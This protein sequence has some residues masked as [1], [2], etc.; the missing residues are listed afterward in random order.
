MKKWIAFFCALCLLLPGCGK[1]DT[2]AADGTTEPTEAEPA[3]V[4]FA[5]SEQDMFTDRDL[6]TYFDAGKAFK[7]QL[8]GDTAA[9]DS[10][11]V[12]INGSTVTITKEGTYVITGTLNDGMLIVAAEETAKLQLVF[13]NVR[14]TNSTGAALYIKEADK[15]FL[16]LVSHYSN[17]LANGGT[18]TPIDDSNIDGALFS[19]QDLTI[20]G[21]GSLTV[22]SPSGHGIVCKDDLV[23]AGGE[24]TINAASHGLDAN[25]SIRL[26]DTVL[27]ITAGKDGLHT[28]NDEDAAKG[29]LYLGSGTLNITAEGDGLSAGSFVQLEG[30]TVNILAGGGSEN[31]TKANSGHYGDFMPG[32]GFGG[33]PGYPGGGY[34]GGG[35]GRPQRPGYGGTDNSGSSGSTSTGTESTSMK[36]IKAG[37]SLLISDGSFDIDSADDAIHA[38]ENATINGGRFTLKTGDDGVHAEEAL[39]ITKCDMTITE[40]YEGLEALHVQV[41]GGNIT[42]TASDDGI[43]AA[44]G[45]DGSGGGGRDGQF[46]GR[47]GGPFGG[48]GNSSGSIVING[49]NVNI[50]ASGDSLDANGTLTI[51][52]GET[53]TTGPIQGDTSVLDFDVSGIV[54]GGTFIGTGAMGM[55]HG[56]T[57]CDQGLVSLRTSGYTAGTLITVKDSD[58]NVIISHT[59]EMD[60]QLIIITCPKMIKGQT[61]TLTIGNASQS[62]TAG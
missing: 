57:Q 2:E 27:N 54:T 46:G 53:I 34:P 36:G 31:G 24:L 15:V 59:P 48:G 12:Q 28:E 1:K 40:S 49:G 52:G 9:S 16:T 58:G 44:G 32:G 41:D 6:R 7:I 26:K 38:N 47:P 37:T 19:R 10:G 3:I 25:D 22:T 11:D 61:Y 14:I 13:Q 55:G 20:N 39:T 42:L 43:N 33:Y 51:N 8:S 29:F 62:I 35:G 18:F 50:T 45:A 23:I 4:D 21:G 60:F 5:Q 17:T 56:F 30:G